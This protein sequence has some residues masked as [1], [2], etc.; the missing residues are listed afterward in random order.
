[1]GSRVQALS[2]VDAVASDMRN[3]LFSGELTGDAQLTEAEV[4]TQYEVA[5]PTAKAAI[6]K[7]VSE[8][9]LVRG[10]HRTAQVLSLT[11]EDI[12]DLYFARRTIE[13]EVVREL[14][15]RRVLPESAPRADADAR[16]VGVGDE[17]AIIEPVMRFHVS[18]VRAVGSER[19]SRLFDTLMGEMHLCMVQMQSRRLL[20]GS[21]IVDEHKPITDA[22]AAGDPEAAV[23]ALYEHLDHAEQR[24]L[25]PESHRAEAVGAE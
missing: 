18:L 24:M 4:A 23:A 20:E 7:L 1:M 8:G 6:E 12:R 10:T 25:N 15:R 17:S 14:A 9:L 16:A 2:I 19:L 13:G 5:R 21:V 3:R 11:E 22:I